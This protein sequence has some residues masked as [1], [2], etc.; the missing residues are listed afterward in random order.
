MALYLNKRDRYARRP[1]KVWRSKW[2][3]EMLFLKQVNPFDRYNSFCYKK[4]T[5]TIKE[6]R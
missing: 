2:L 3:R 5:I 6:K 1:D 4:D